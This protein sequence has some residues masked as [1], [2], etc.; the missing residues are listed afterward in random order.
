MISSFPWTVENDK[1]SSFSGERRR[2]LVPG[3]AVLPELPR[4]ASPRMTI[5]SRGNLLPFHCPFCAWAGGLA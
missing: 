5:P 1:P 4:V 2:F 3:L